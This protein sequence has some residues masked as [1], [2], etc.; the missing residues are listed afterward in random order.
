MSTTARMTRRP[1]ARCYDI[2]AV[3]RHIER[4][5]TPTEIAERWGLSATTVRDMFA[6][7]PGVLKFEQPR[8]RGKRRYVSLRIPESVV[9][10]AYQRLT[11]SQEIQRGGSGV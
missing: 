10:Q 5:Y 7:M 4:H 11:G 2:P 3:E 9:L 8:M 6:D 1:A